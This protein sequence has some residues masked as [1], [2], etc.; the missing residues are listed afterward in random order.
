[1][2][3]PMQRHMAKVREEQAKSQAK[4]KLDQGTKQDALDS[5]TDY[6]AFEAIKTS[7]DQD[8]KSL[9]AKTQ[10]QER[11]E[12]REKTLLPRYMPHLLAYKESGEEYANPVLV[13][14]VMWLMDLGRIGE[15]LEWA[16]LAITQN[17][18]M[19]GQWNRNLATFVADSVLK[20]AE[21]E[22]KA[23]HA[24]DPYFTSVFENLVD[25]P[26]PDVVKMK[27]NKLAGKMALKEKDFE[28]AESFLLMADSLGDAAHP[29]KV[30]TDLEKAQKANEKAKAEEAKA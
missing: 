7:L 22:F 15:A 18:K 14:V 29:A 30:S 26:V 27:Y 9:G 21:K 8:I 5:A 2:T 11:N 17:Q 1:M 4:E 23:G 3:S 13:A 24:V 19:P 12:Y 16:Y 25:W 10:G 20:W 6:P 28:S